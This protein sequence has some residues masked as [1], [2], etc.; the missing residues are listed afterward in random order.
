MQ[1]RRRRRRRARLVRVDR[2]VALG[3][4]QRL[5]DVRRQR[6]LARRLAVQSQAPTA[7][8]EMLEQ[9]DGTVAGADTEPP[10]RPREALPQAVSVQPLEQEHLTART[11]DRN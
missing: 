4:R 3:I 1:P 9:L 10:R 7:L 2:L 8:A 11:L 6:R 5:R